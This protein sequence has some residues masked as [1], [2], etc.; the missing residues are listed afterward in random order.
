[1]LIQNHIMKIVCMTCARAKV[2]SLRVCV[3]YLRLIQMNAVNKEVS[4][5]GG[6]LFQS[7]V[8]KIKV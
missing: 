3:R 2:T 4:F 5:I 8:K 7:A 6:N 1:M